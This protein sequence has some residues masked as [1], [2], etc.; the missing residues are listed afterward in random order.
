MTDRDGE[1]VRYVERSELAIDVKKRLN[2][3]LH[4]LLFGAAIADD[5]HLYFE[6][7]VFAD[8]QAGFG[9]L[10]ERDAAHV[11]EL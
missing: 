1:R 11:R 2:H 9:G 7:R 5:A 8:C 10:E 6:R 4:L 3:H